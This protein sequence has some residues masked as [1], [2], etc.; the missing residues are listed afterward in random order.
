MPKWEAFEAKLLAKGIIP[1][2]A[3][4]PERSKFWLYAH[5]ASLDPQTGRIVANGK[6]KEKVEMTSRRERM[7][8]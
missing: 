1:Q 5:G 3:D 4:W 7:T 8:Q 2:T 6:W